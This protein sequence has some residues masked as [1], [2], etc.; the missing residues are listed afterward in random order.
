M[1]R[2]FVA[3]SNIS[4]GIAFIDGKEA[5]HMRVLR[6]RQGESFT[7][8]DGNGNDHICKIS[9]EK[10]GAFCAEILKT[11]PSSG[12]P[13][14]KCS[15]Y[16]AFSKGDKMDTV[17]QKCVELGA[18]E[19]VV[20]P[21][22]RCVSKPDGAAVIKKTA[23]WQKIAAEAAKQSGRGIIPQVV[24]LPDFKS[25]VK[26]AAEADLP[27]FCYEEEDTLSLKSAAESKTDI[28][29]ISI[30]TGPEGGFEP[31]EAE[32]AKEAGLLSVSL[33]PRIL[34]CETAPFAAL[35]AIMYATDNF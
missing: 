12:E 17:V 6:I 18:F 22:Y 29:T 7:V 10:D 27:L 31:D 28:K 25:A 35:A 13:S 11:V 24:S 2:F 1:S 9:D 32:A 34:R 3:A 21:S 15:V 19:I 20:F 23:R 4:G 5:E 14:V 8:C 16:A 30:I 26:R 33:G